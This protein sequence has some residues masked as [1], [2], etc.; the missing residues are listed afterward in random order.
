[1]DLFAPR[2]LRAAGAVRDPKKSLRFVE[3]GGFKVAEIGHHII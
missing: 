1:M 2:R 3:E